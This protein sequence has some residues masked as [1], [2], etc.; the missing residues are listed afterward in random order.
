MIDR[1]RISAIRGPG[2]LRGAAKVIFGF[3]ALALYV[4][5]YFAIDFTDE[6]FYVALPY[7]FTLGHRPLQ[8]ELSVHQFAGLILVP[9][10]KAYLLAWNSSDG[11]VLFMRHLYFA[12]SILASY[13]IATRF[14][15]IVGTSHGIAFAAIVLV[16]IPFSIPSLSYNTIAYLG[17]LAGL[18]W[19]AFSDSSKRPGLDLFWGALSL[20]LVCVA[21][22]TLSPVAILS[23]LL[24]ILIRSRNLSGL[25]KVRAAIPILPV[26]LFWFA[27]FVWA[28]LTF[29]VMKNLP[30][31]I[32]LNQL[33]GSQGGG[34]SKFLALKEEFLRQAEMF[35]AIAAVLIAVGVGLRKARNP[36]SL[37]LVAL[38]TG[39]L[40]ML[41]AEL[42]VPRTEPY[43][44][45]T[46]VIT[47]LACISLYAL[48]PG[49][50][51][52]GRSYVTTLGILVLGSLFAGASILWSTANGLRNAALGLAPACLVGL[53]V[54]S[55]F[56]PEA[57][58]DR[59]SEGEAASLSL[60]RSG[61][62]LLMS[63]SILIYELLQFQAGVYRDRPLFDLDSR[64]RQG[65]YAGLF[66]TAERVDFIQTLSESLA[67]LGKNRQ[68][69]VFFDYFPA[70]YLFTELR[71]LTSALW[72]FPS[73]PLLQGNPRIR[74][75]YAERFGDSVQLPDL[76]VIMKLIPVGSRFIGVAPERDDPVLQKLNPQDYVVAANTPFYLILEKDA[77]KR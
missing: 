18:I 77:L 39:P 76:A 24:P 72:M 55:N 44:T 25:Q 12:G 1:E 63:L 10:V 41:A 69:I 42:Y 62:V 32:E 64:V 46:F 11:L 3:A 66:T 57:K 49:A 71:P 40:L 45:T 36:W 34:L 37:M 74:V 30:R 53:C 29:D 4:R 54:V 70:G 5:L 48:R 47:A 7:S 52:L 8:D 28:G 68:T 65:P 73:N 60:F 19:V 6:S 31:M 2:V 75:P 51:V 59:E 26:A 56:F 61:A 20:S 43:T 17:M 13:L 27:V 9:F 23:C 35:L 38:S 16:Y 33:L 21:Y 15:R 67:D 50:G 58:I 22:P 14:G